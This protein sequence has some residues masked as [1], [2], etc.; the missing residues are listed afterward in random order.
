MEAVWQKIKADII[1]RPLI[2]GLIL[3]AIT[4]SATLLTL[5]LATLMNINAP[6]D[7]AFEELNAAH[8]WLYFNRD[9]VSLRDITRIEALPGVVES[10]GLRYSA[11]SRVRVGDA[12]VWVSL[13]AVPTGTP[14]VNRLLVQEGR[15]LEPHQA[16]LLASKDLDDIYGLAVGERIGIT[17]E[18]GKEVALPVI[19]LA[20]NPMWDTYRSSQPPYVYVSEE[21]LREL[22]PDDST[23]DWSIGLRLA[24][25]DAVDEIV[26]LIE[27]TFH[28]NVVESHTDWRDVKESAVFGAQL[29]FVFLGAFSFFAVLATVL[30]VSSTIGSIILSQFRQIG[31]LKAIGFT[32]P[33]VVW[34]YLGQCLALGLI[35]SALGLLLGF[36]LSPLPLRSIAASLATPYHPP[37][38][39]ALAITVVGAM[40]G[41]VALASLGAASRGARANIIRSI[42]VGAE[43]PR[44]KS[45]G[46]AMLATRLGLS[47]TITLGLNEIFVRPFR[48][49]VTGFNLTLGV[50]GIVF[51]LALSETLDTYREN[52]ALLGVVYDA[53]VTREGSG[54]SKTRHLLETAPGVEGFYSEYLVEVE[55]PVGQKF[56]V[57][58]VEGELER[59]PFKVD[60]GR[61][62]RP[63]TYE[64]IAGEGLLDWLEL[65]VGD[66]ITVTLEGEKDR[67]VTWRIVGQYPETVNAGQM[68]MVSL[69]AVSRLVKQAK[70][71][72]YFLKLGTDYDPGRLKEYLGAGPGGDL[73][74]ILV[75]EVITDDVFYLE[76]AIFTLSGLL[77]GIALINVFNSSLLAVQ[78]KLRT[79][80]ILKAI[81]MTPAQVMTMVG[82]T[83]GFLA[84][85]AAILG[86]PIGIMFTGGLMNV[87]AAGYGFGRVSVTLRGI[88]IVFLVPVTILISMS[89]SLIP[90]RWAAKRPVMSVL[91]SE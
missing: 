52:P 90:G 51:G 84:L 69:P 91:R 35:G 64:A 81:G 83:A 40:L 41:V 31:I 12:Q 16:E 77:M 71:D 58:A 18:D 9:R 47:P 24:D 57:R 45:F 27:E 72:T 11:L 62:F 34:L 66:D 55:T 15:G 75:E 48:S 7:R 43:R 17:R 49:L 82:V 25:P 20:Y 85:L 3:V 39:P 73:N 37:L 26:A 2:S 1:S 87:L 8:V 28:S 78:E 89:G 59:F 46:G 50:I 70:P 88:Y 5:A 54:D 29:N 19:G 86:T 42:T 21:T 60:Q 23:W 36:I 6:Y 56:Q 79:V 22:F 68:M 30:V 80:G 53:V 10:T 33:Q 13:R 74:L 67:P 63:N 32:S 44:E 76:L 61:F 65:E 14:A 38:D 4:V